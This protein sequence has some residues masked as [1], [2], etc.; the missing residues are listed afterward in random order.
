MLPQPE[1][2]VIPK[3]N[4]NPP[5]SE[6]Q[7]ADAIAGVERLRQVDEARDL[8]RG[9]AGDGHRDGQEP[10][11]QPARVAEVHDVA[12]RAH[13]AEVDA[14]RDG[15]EHGGEQEREPG[16]ERGQMTDILH[17][18]IMARERSRPRAPPGARRP[19]PSAPARR[20]VN[21]VASR[22]AVY[23]DIGG[24]MGAA[25]PTEIDHGSRT[26]TSGR[27]FRCTAQISAAPARRRTARA[28]AC[29]RARASARQAPPPG[30]SGSIDIV[31]R[32][33]GRALPVYAK[34]GRSC[35]V[36]TP[37]QEYG[38][39]VCNTTGERVLAVMSVDGVNIVSGET[40]SPSQ[41]GYVL[42]GVRVRRHQ[43]L[44][45]ESRRPP[46][47]ST[48]PSCPTRTRRARGVPTTSASSASRSS[49]SGRSASVWKDSPQDRRR[50]R[51]PSPRSGRTP[52]AA[53]CSAAESR[54]SNDA[55]A[56]KEMAAADRRRAARRSAKIGTGHGRHEQS[57]V[58]TTRFVRESATPN[59][60]LAIHYDRRE[61]L[62]AMGVLPPPSIARIGQSVSR[63]DPAVRAGSAATR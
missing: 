18:Q 20:S 5:T 35:V 37:G 33:D 36:G 46:R 62:I 10:H 32:P 39:R 22:R 56:R 29:R 13:R 3:P 34:D 17:G 7:P 41:S 43:R 58:Q 59:E 57:Y 51:R 44:A 14:G 16:D 19:S 47:R 52:R 23:R 38:I 11:P 12:D 61:N 2:S 26:A 1:P 55:A 60:T 53:R 21:P 4:R 40:A 15:A 27:I 49:A 25:T 54:A 30:S 31:T 28:R 45:Q 42:S 63:V 24:A 8:Q 48:S 9:G 50:A 6:R